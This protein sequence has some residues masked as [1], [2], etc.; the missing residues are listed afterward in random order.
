MKIPGGT[1]LVRW[2]VC[3]VSGGGHRRRGFVVKLVPVP[4]NASDPRV[5]RLRESYAVERRF[6]AQ[7]APRMRDEGGPPAPRL[8][9]SDDLEG[10]GPQPAVCFLLTDL[11]EQ[12]F[13][14]HPDFLSPSEAARA[15]RWCAAMHAQFWG[16]GKT[17]STRFA[18][19]W[20][21]H[22]WDRGGYWTIDGSG[23]D[24]GGDPIDRSAVASQWSQTVRWA[25][26]RRPDVITTATAG[27]GRRIAAASGAVASYLANEARG[28]RGTLIHGDF[29]AA[30][31]FFAA[32]DGEG[33]EESPG[34]G[35]SRREGV[36]VEESACVVGA[37]SVAA[38]DFQFAGRGA[39]A[40]DVAY[41]LFP[42]AKGHYFE[43]EGALLKAYHEELVNCLIFRGK[44]GPSTLSF[45]EF[46]LQYNLSRLDFLRHLLSRGWVGSTDG[47]ALLLKATEETIDKL[48][49]GE[50]LANEAEYTR[51]ILRLIN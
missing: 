46:E 18:L 33:R 25:Q 40:E 48:D 10:S 9:A 16:E 39:G 50:A 38:L 1:E 17:S 51:R 32:V 30:N 5:R 41:L 36:K 20:R 6:Y 27:L 13:P 26:S 28:A 11:R 21:D 42:D 19:G 45:Q 8:L 12:G 35:I 43:E 49:G 37:A 2:V 47:D 24:K 31:L 22:L 4:G 14:R 15:L 23:S 34:D 7:V 3:R 44:G 29:K